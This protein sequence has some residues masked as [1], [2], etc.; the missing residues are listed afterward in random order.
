MYNLARHWIVPSIL[1]LSLGCSGQSAQFDEDRTDQ[2][3]EECLT[4]CL[5]KGASEEA[6]SAYCSGEESKDVEGEGKGP[7]GNGKS[8]ER[9]S[10]DAAP[11]EGAET[12]MTGISMGDSGVD[13]DMNAQPEEEGPKAEWTEAEVRAKGCVQCWYDERITGGACQAEVAACE[14]SLACTQLQW[15][16]SLCD[17]EDCVDECNDIIPSGVPILQAVIQCLACD[18]GPCTEA[19]VDTP[20]ETYCD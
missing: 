17:R 13:S 3:D 12:P 2:I 19:C 5:A 4:Q 9:Q 14:A 10:R 16:P 7:K 1:A 15:C 8:P 11:E 18:D 6:C 20:M